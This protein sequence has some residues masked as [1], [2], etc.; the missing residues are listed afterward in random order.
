MIDASLTEAFGVLFEPFWMEAS[1]FRSLDGVLGAV[2]GL[3]KALSECVYGA[4]VGDVPPGEVQQM[5]EKTNKQAALSLF[6]LR[7]VWAQFVLTEDLMSA[8]RHDKLTLS[9]HEF[10]LFEVWTAHG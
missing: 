5:V 1:G 7:V 2:S 8:A 9:L 3:C 6:P 10:M 4:N